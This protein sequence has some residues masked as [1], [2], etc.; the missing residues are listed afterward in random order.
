MFRA[1]DR[2]GAN[3]LNNCHW[4]SS[5]IP[6]CKDKNVAHFLDK[7]NQLLTG[8]GKSKY[9]FKPLIMDK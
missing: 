2:F 9:Q 5:N 3:S 8:K 6:D 4:L 1:I 7:I